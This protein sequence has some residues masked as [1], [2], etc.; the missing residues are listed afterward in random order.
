LTYARTHGISK[1]TRSEFFLRIS[2]QTGLQF[3]LAREEERENL[4]EYLKRSGLWEQ[5]S[6][7]KLPRLKKAIADGGF[8][9]KTIR[10]L[11]E[12]A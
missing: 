11:L 6:G 4:E 10:A 9:D 1:I 12:F 3:P 7:L 2:K 5:V 8:D